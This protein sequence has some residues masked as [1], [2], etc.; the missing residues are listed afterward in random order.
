MERDITQFLAEPIIVET[1]FYK[2]H[3]NGCVGY[4]VNGLKSNDVIADLASK[5]KAEK[6][7]NQTLKASIEL[8]EQR[9]IKPM[10]E[11]LEEIKTFKCKV[12]HNHCKVEQCAY[13]IADQALN[14]KTIPLKEVMEKEEITCNG[15]GLNINKKETSQFGC[16]NCGKE[17][18]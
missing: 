5:L 11:A 13:K 6:A 18:Q 10:R 2:V 17:I 3:D 15:C 12:C 16:W 14:P 7:E 4:K 8:Q 1:E 9:V